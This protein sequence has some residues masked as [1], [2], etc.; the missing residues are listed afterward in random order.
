MEEHISQIAENIMI[1][2][3]HKLLSSESIETNV[4]MEQ[5][6]RYIWKRKGAYHSFTL[7][8]YKTGLFLN[9]EESFCKAI[10]LLE[11]QRKIKL[12]YV[13]KKR[14]DGSVTTTEIH[15]TT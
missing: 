8:N 6:R 9:E 4:L 11:H 2:R 12:K 5:L 7:H 15:F 13:S 3:Y 14:I 1:F 10:S